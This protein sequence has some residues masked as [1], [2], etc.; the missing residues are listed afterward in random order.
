MLLSSFSPKAG[1]ECKGKKKPVIAK[2][3][4]WRRGSDYEA[5]ETERSLLRSVGWSAG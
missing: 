2:T 3:T 4:K 5:K 1:N